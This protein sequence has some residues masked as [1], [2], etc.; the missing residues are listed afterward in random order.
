[1]LSDFQPWIERWGLE[2]DGEP[3]VTPWSS[4]LLP[5]RHLSRAAML[6]VA[7]HPEEQRGGA[8]MAWYAGDGAAIVYAHDEQAVVLERLDGPRLLANMAREG[9]DEAACRIL[10]ETVGRLHA[11]RPRPPPAAAIPL[12]R[13]F[14]ALWPQ[15]ERSGGLYATSAAVARELLS[16][17]GA[18]VMLHGDIHHG[19]V[20]DGG[21][22]GWLAIDPKGLLGDRGYDYA[23]LICNPDAETALVHFDR[24]LDI[25]AEVSGLP[26]ESVLSWLLAYTG[27]SA[28]WTLSSGG[29]PWQAVAI[30]DAAAARLGF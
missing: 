4:R 7:L 2:P 18:Q 9:Q 5:V 26:R 25:V 28:S 23:N 3:F 11:P 24:R 30:G 6:K 10:S 14:D 12:H 27:L 13:W 20:L 21:A 17:P 19:N 15:A 22:R 16:E 29:D 8:V 1:M